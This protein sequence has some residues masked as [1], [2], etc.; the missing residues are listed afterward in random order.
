VIAADRLR[1]PSPL[2]LAA[3]AYK[4][5]LHVNV[6]DFARERVGLVNVSLHGDPDDPGSLAAGA[7][8]L[9]DLRRGWR[10]HVE[11][12]A[13]ADAKRADGE[14]AVADVAAIALDEARGGLDV[15]GRLPRGDV[16]L[17]A[18]AFPSA[19]PIVA[20]QPTPFGSG[21]IAWRAMPR[22]SVA[23]WL[24]VDGE[25]RSGDDIAAYHDHNWGRWYWGDDAG[26][27]WGAFLSPDGAAFVTTR[28]T[29]RSHRDGGTAFRAHVGS[30]TRSFHPRTVHSRLGGR[31]EDAP[32]RVPGAMAA[33]HAGRAQPRLP[34]RVSVFADDG[35]DHVELE[36]SFEHAAQIVVAEPACP[37]YGFIH[38]LIGRFRYR[39]RLG[40][41][42]ATG[43]GLVAFEYVD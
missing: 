30:Q 12:V 4:D 13:A 16:E 35:Y 15:Q 22:M 40:G 29:D 5:W 20:E 9:G 1:P 34:S 24:R 39:T 25:M 10:Q 26:W 38:E 43:E 27:E 14:I 33:L 41:A 8:L 18:A 21:W 36:A 42:D 17:Q 31:L 6:F 37:G 28:P 19:T 32:G 23:G 7:V 2:D 11:V 3:S